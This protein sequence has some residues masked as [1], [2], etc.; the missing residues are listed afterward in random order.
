MTILFAD[1]TGSL[2][3]I[4]GAD[5]E[6]SQAIL[7]AA[8]GAMMGAVHRF[9]GTVNKVLGD[10]IMAIFGAPL[11][12]EDHAVRACYAA[13][14]LQQAMTD[15]AAETR[16]RHGVEAQA[17]VGLHSGEVVV[18]AI[19]NDLSMDYDAI[20]PT[21]HIAGRMEQL[22]TPGSIRITGDTWRLAEGFVEARQLGPTSIRGVREPVE[23]FELTGSAAARSR[24]EVRAKRG[25][26]KFV[27][28]E[29]E[30]A[31]L[32][33]ALEQAAASRGQAVVVVGEPGMGKSRLVHEFVPS[34]VMHGWTVL[35]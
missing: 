8:V 1:L 16:R 9:E 20:G 24:W 17:R 31:I 22:A 18:R 15:V 27:G 21:V 19:G 25:L 32:V 11:A 34:G 13:L 7:D 3:M 6:H 4:E 5:P 29:V 33:H 2:E 30:V 35:E 14:T 10:G 26:T 12:L 23:L 28:R